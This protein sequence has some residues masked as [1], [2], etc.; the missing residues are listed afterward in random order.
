[1]ASNFRELFVGIDPLRMS[2][3][4]V[5]RGAGLRLIGQIREMR[6]KLGTGLDRLGKFGDPRGGIIRAQSG[7]LT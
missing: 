6:G 2:R 3:K 5:P 7:P 4:P 1:M